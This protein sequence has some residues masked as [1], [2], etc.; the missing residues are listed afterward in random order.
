MSIASINT[1]SIADEIRAVRRASRHPLAIFDLT[2]NAKPIYAGADL[3]VC[4]SAFNKSTFDPN[5]SISIPQF[6]RYQFRDERPVIASRR[7]FLF[8]FKGDLRENCTSLRRTLLSLNGCPCKYP[9]IVIG[10]TLMP[11]NIFIRDNEAYEVTQAGTLPYSTVMQNSTF[12]LLPRGCGH[13]LSSRFVEALAL[14]CIPVIISDE[15]VLPFSEVLEYE[16][17]AIVIP[18]NKVLELPD[19][20]ANH[21]QNA[22]RMQMNALSAYRAYFASTEIIMSHTIKLL[23]Q[24]V[25]W[26][27]IAT[28]FS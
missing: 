26:R 6:P 10:T 5:S 21:I 23:L 17:F 7:K 25:R 22:D 19:L 14:G 3:Y 12:A 24:K 28:E 13:A 15:T 2:D 4:K 11:E 20:L 1:R 18:E 8:G 16:N 9:G 27:N